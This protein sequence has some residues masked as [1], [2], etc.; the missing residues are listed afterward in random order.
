LIAKSHK[1]EELLIV[2]S[3][4]MQVLREDYHNT[5]KDNSDTTQKEDANLEH[6]GSNVEG[7]HQ[8]SHSNNVAEEV[9][10]V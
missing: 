2:N 8:D 4:D 6:E 9:Q 1:G 3:V 10:P 7:H 5:A